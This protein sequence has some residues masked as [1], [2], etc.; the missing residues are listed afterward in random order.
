MQVVIDSD[1]NRI[2]VLGAGSSVGYGLPAWKE[3]GKMISEELNNDKTDT[4]KHK[5]SIRNWISKVGD[6]KKY[7]TI[8]ECI[9]EESS[10]KEFHSDGP[11]IENEIFLAIKNTFLRLYKENPEEWIMVLNEKILRDKKS[12]HE[13]KLAFINYNYDNVLE[14]NFLNF[15]YLSEKQRLVNRERLEE[16]SDHRVTALFPHGNFHLSDKVNPHGHISKVSNTFKSFDK[17]FVDAVSCH[18]S[19]PHYISKSGYATYSSKLYILGLSGG[20]QVN[21]DRINFDHLIN[22]V[23][24]TIHNKNYKDELIDY[25]CKK[26]KKDPSSIKVYDSCRDLIEKCF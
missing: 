2:L 17:K 18:E 20:L 22:E 10:S 7:K 1:V 24:I 25:L 13:T 16:L 12:S 14:K 11:E 15:S 6:C 5:D 26:Y 9:K 21:L 3:L 4:Y 8:D 19:E 23:H